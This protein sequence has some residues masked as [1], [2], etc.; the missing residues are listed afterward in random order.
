MEQSVHL[1]LFSFIIAGLPYSGKT[2]LVN[3]LF[4]PP[5]R[6]DMQAINLH[7][8]IIYRQKMFGE[9][10]WFETDGIL[11]Q[12]SSI[13]VAFAQ[14]FARQQ[15]LPDHDQKEVLKSESLFEDEEIQRYFKTIYHVLLDPV[16]AID[17]EM[18]IEK[19]LHSSLSLVN[20]FDIG[21][22]KGVYEF[23]KAIG[24]R[25]KRLFLINV[26][27]LFLS[28]E[29]RMTS[30][31]D[32]ADYPDQYAKSQISFFQDRTVLQQFVNNMEAA[33]LSEPQATSNTL[34]VG[35]HADKFDSPSECTKRQKEVSDL[36]EKYGTDMGYKSDTFS[37]KMVAVD[38]QHGDCQEVKNTLCRMIDDKKFG[39]DLPVKYIFLRYVL[40]QTKKLYLPRDEI[41]CYARKCGFRNDEIDHFLIVYR[42]C[43]SIFAYSDKNHFLYSYVIL[44]PIKF[45]RDLDKLYCIQEDQTVSPEVKRFAKCGMLSEDVLKGLWKSFD[46]KPMPRWDFN[47]NVLKSVLL[48]VDVS[49]SKF[50]CPSLRLEHSNDLLHPDSL[51]I[52]SAAAFTSSCLQCAFVKHLCSKHLRLDEECPYYDSLK[53]FDS[54]EARILIRFFQDFIEVFVE[55]SN[56]SATHADELYSMLKTE[57]AVIMKESKKFNSATYNFS[58]NCPRSSLKPLEPHFAKFD[59]LD[60]SSNPWCIKCNDEVHEPKVLH[61]VKATYKGKLEEAV[62]MGG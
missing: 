39:I 43:A 19:I 40:H 38:A 30:V 16:L 21:V 18:K 52:S 10:F 34:I 17:S 29:K 26:L 1:E 15:E 54:K 48:L 56:I 35:T 11:T 53:F 31:L 32:P 24:G 61:W 27:D 25:E 12:V 5:Q 62:Q 47:I 45:M 22:N 33:S 7:E 6:K 55:P 20:V 49:R 28:D 3:S 58:I 8:A 46:D 41:K 13:L 23:L 50:F 51:I 44:L 9:S 59:I 42:S 4:K 37:H 14:F 60:A 36:L 2:T 57:C